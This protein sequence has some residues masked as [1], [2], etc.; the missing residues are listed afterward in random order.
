MWL[1]IGYFLIWNLRV[2]WSL[3]LFTHTDRSRPSL[4][5]LV[6]SCQFQEELTT[7]GGFIVTSLQGFCYLYCCILLR[8]SLGK[9]P[10]NEFVPHLLYFLSPGFMTYIVEPLFERWAQFT[11]DTPLSENM[12]NH[13]RRNKAKWRSLLHKQHS[14]SRSNDHSGQVTGSQEQTLNEEET[15]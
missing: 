3:T 6:R 11:G 2:G 15:P 5:A 1:Y 8:H 14:S 10:R 12:L 13:L 4:Y 7:A 9:C